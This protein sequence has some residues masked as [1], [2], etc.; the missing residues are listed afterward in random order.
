[1]ISYHFLN[2]TTRSNFFTNDSAHGAG[3]LWSNVPYLPSY[4]QT[5]APFPLVVFDSTPVG[6]NVTYPIPLEPVVYE[7]R[8]TVI[9]K[10][11]IIIFI[12]L[13]ASPLEFGSYDPSL[14]AMV[15]LTYAGTSLLNGQPA[16]GS[17]CVTGFD[18]VGFVMGTSSNLFNVSHTRL[19]FLLDRN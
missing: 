1:M 6:S 8:F 4:K 17:A 16:N 15:N 2:E 5:L 12:L 3:Q 18:Q 14:S 19:I 7:V 13:K 11:N 10:N 9:L